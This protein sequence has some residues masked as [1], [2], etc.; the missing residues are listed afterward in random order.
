M[1]MAKKVAK[2]VERSGAPAVDAPLARIS[3]R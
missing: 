1:V 2:E 3:C